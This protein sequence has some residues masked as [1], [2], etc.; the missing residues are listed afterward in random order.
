[1]DP[2]KIVLLSSVLF[3]Y[4][5]SSSIYC[6]VLSRSF[7]SKQ[8]CVVL[9]LSCLRESRARVLTPG[10]W[11][12]AIK[13]GQ[14]TT[15]PALTEELVRKHLPKEVATVKCHLNQRCNNLRS[16]TRPA[17]VEENP[18]GNDDFEADP[19]C[20]RGIKTHHVFTLLLDVGKI[21][22]DLT[23]HFPHTSSKGNHYILV[24]YDYDGNTVATDAMKNRT[25]KETVRAYSKLHQQLVDAGLK[26]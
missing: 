23:G 7:I 22:G 26:P 9:L 1:M 13:A 3:N 15:W 20:T 24:V 12:K 4:Y 16:T 17:T 6:T 25:D 10:T 14:F 21:Y 11:I 8:S 5:V 18:I 2:I 19:P